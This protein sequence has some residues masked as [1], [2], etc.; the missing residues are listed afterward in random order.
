MMQS[1]ISI[2]QIQ[3]LELQ[4]GSNV[5][6]QGSCEFNT[7]AKRWSSVGYQTPVFS[8]FIYSTLNCGC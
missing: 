3:E 6:K 1:K 4:L 8:D 7:S 5:F 2:A